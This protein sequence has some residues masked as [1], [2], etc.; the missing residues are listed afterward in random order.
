MGNGAAK[1]SGA[2]INSKLALLSS[3][4]LLKLQW[5]PLEWD[6]QTRYQLIEAIKCYA[7][8]SQ[9]GVPCARILL[10]GH[11]NVGKSS[12]FNT[13]NSIFRNHVTGQAPVGSPR[14]QRSVTTKMRGYQVRNGREGKILNLKIVDTM[15]LE[16]ERKKGFDPSEL[17]YIL[18]GH[19]PDN[20]KFDPAGNISAEMPGYLKAPRLEDK[21]HCCVFVLDA[22]E[23]HNL[24]DNLSQKFSDM[25]LK[26][27][28]RGIP[29]LVL[30]TKIDR[31]C[32]QVGA[33][34][35]LVYRSI[36]IQ[37]LIAEASLKIGVPVSHILPIKNYTHE[38]ELDTYVDVLALS[39]LQQMLRFTDNYFDECIV[40]TKLGYVQPDTSSN[41]LWTRQATLRT[42]NGGSHQA[43]QAWTV[44]G[45]VAT[46]NGVLGR[47]GGPSVQSTPLGRSIFNQN[48]VVTPIGTMA[49]GDVGKKR[50]PQILEES[51]E[52]VQKDEPS[53]QVDKKIEDPISPLKIEM[54][55]ESPNQMTVQV[56]A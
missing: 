21:I 13:V 24:K 16:E 7:P 28:G 18:D 23:I 27:T 35:S 52:D 32:N 47:L 36:I 31:V 43:K 34:L 54:N 8:L 42:A 29:L 6:E 17:S 30:V 9:I 11:V 49:T 41:D 55:G 4:G 37:N 56:A 14:D 45:S 2:A 51:V 20:H 44:S 40:Q 12:Y 3:S 33:D 5:R 50:E 53:P 10:L 15:G 1:R 39:A 22:S 46:P 26:I 38:I 19:V 25:R 48:N